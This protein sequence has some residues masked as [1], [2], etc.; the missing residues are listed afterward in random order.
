MRVHCSIY[1]ELDS[2]SPRLTAHML[3]IFVRPSRV[4]ADHTVFCSKDTVVKKPECEAVL[5]RPSAK[6]KDKPAVTAV[7]V[8]IAAVVR[9]GCAITFC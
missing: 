3:H 6:M 1:Q 4:C 8:R 9:D 2:G 7:T 5:L